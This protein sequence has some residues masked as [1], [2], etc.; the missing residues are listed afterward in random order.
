MRCMDW[1]S[2]GTLWLLALIP[3]L[4]HPAVLV[5]YFQRFRGRK[6]VLLDII[7]RSGD[8]STHFGSTQKQIGKWRQHLALNPAA[9]MFPAALCTLLS[10]AAGISL[11]CLHDT[12]KLIE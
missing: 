3:G 1:G 2:T 7:N 8:R 6:N 4:L 11:V 5:I 9:Y 12:P 10:L